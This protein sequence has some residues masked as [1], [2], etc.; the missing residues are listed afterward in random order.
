MMMMMMMM[1][2][3]KPIVAFN[4]GG[5]AEIIVHQETGILVDDIDAGALGNAISQ[6]IASQEIRGQ[7]GINGRH[8]LEEKFTNNMQCQKIERLIDGF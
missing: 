3:S 7:L 6:L 4:L 2:M 5:P 1:M 8:R